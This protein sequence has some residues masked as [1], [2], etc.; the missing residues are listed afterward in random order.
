M[1]DPERML[2]PSRARAG[3]LMSWLLPCPRL[4]DGEVVAYASTATTL[5][6]LLQPR[7]PFKARQ[8][9]QQIQVGGA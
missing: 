5:Q 7:G 1:D 6:V 9:G 8:R 4:Q 3:S 2:L